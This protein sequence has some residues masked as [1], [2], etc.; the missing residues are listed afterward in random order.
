VSDN[1]DVVINVMPGVGPQG[2]TGATGIPGPVGPSGVVEVNSAIEEAAAW[3][4]GAKIV[5]RLDLL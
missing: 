2:A 1:I 3:L 5:I 4:A